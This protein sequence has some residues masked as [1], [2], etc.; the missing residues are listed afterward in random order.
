MSEG[1]QQWAFKLG[2]VGS[3]EGDLRQKRHLRLSQEAVKVSLASFLKSK[4]QVDHTVPSIS[5][6]R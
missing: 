1:E 6:L 5:T 3:R 2:L 4:I